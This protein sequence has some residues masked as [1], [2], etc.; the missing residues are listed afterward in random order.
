MLLT[1]NSVH[2]TEFGA[3]MWIFF[4][5]TPK[6]NLIWL[7]DKSNMEGKSIS[8]SGFVVDYAL[9]INIIVFFA[10]IPFINWFQGLMQQTFLEER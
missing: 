2:V 6:R 1:S 3:H 9:G 10:L 4:Y 8:V 5:Q 7:Q